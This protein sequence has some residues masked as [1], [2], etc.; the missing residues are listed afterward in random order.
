ARTPNTA[1]HCSPSPTLFSTAKVDPHFPVASVMEFPCDL[2]ADLTRVVEMRSAKRVAVV[3][4]V[5]CVR[6]VQRTEFQRQILANLLRHGEIDL[7]VARQMCR[8]VSVEKSRSVTHIGGNP[9]APRQSD[10]NTRGER[11]PL[12][13][14]EKEIALCRRR[15]IGEPAR[16][17]AFA[18]RVLVR[19]R[20]VPFG[21]IEKPRRTRCHFPA[22]NARARNGEREKYI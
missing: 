11:V 10:V 21:T 20:Q 16:H 17:S 19:K 3:E 15:E 4:Q 22:S 6:G 13:V 8:S 9:D 18:L 7:R 1:A 12:V 5:A 2:A 14:V